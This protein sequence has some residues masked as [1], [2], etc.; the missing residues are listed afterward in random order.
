MLQVKGIANAKVLGWEE[1]DRVKE[2]QH[3][4]GRVVQG[5]VLLVLLTFRAGGGG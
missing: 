1:I 4:W 2:G 3:G 5:D